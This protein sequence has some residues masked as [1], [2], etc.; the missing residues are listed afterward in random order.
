MPPDEEDE[1]EQLAEGLT[2]EA[3][4][5]AREITERQPRMRRMNLT[6]RPILELTDGD[7][8]EDETSPEDEGPSGEPNTSALAAPP[9]PRPTRRPRRPAAARRFF[10]HGCW[11]VFRS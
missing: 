4:R 5:V 3:V 8:E 11:S 7:A 6:G 10:G 1:G 9:G 2:S